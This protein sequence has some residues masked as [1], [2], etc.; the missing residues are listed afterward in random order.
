MNDEIRSNGMISESHSFLLL[1]RNGCRLSDTTDRERE[2]DLSIVKNNVR[3][4]FII[5]HD[6]YSSERERDKK[7]KKEK[8]LQGKQANKCVRIC[9]IW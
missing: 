2:R 4:L 7:K 3:I 1:M 5:L 6:K 8:K 9:F